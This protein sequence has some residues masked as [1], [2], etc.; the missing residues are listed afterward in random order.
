MFVRKTVLI[1]WRPVPAVLIFRSFDLVATPS[2][3]Q[4]TSYDFAI[5]GDLQHISR[6]PIA[7][8]NRERG[9]VF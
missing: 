7:R 6:I 4:I 2:P 8:S 5:K 9:A 1:V 3:V